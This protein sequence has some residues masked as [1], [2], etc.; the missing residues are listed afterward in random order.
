MT[1]PPGRPAPKTLLDRPVNESPKL[2]AGRITG[3]AGVTPG[4]A[5]CCKSPILRTQRL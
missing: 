4:L 1:A 2:T 5:P 3:N